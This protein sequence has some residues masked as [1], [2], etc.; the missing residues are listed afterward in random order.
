M[1]SINACWNDGNRFVDTVAEKQSLCFLGRRNDCHGSIAEDAAEFSGAFSGNEM[2][3][4][5][6]MNVIFVHGV[7]SMYHRNAKCGGNEF[8]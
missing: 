7:I 8:S 4:G 2:S 1:R 3:S 6:V 5:N